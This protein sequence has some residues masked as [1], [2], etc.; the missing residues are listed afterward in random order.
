M[1][2]G[3]CRGCLT[4][5]AGS[6]GKKA[7]DGFIVSRFHVQGGK[8][9]DSP[10]SR[11]D[12]SDSKGMCHS[13]EGKRSEGGEEKKEENQNKPTWGMTSYASLPEP[14]GF[15]TAAQSR[16]GEAEYCRRRDVPQLPVPPRQSPWRRL[17]S[18]PHLP[19]RLSGLLRSQN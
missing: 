18:I 7:I 9:G 6:R 15:S 1:Y 2:R 4:C 3:C 19:P 13:S 16:H 12:L 5:P 11:P 17:P 10:L 8:G 14:R